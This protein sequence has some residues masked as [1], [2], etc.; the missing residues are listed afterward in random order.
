MPEIHIPDLINIG[1]V[2]LLVFAFV[3]GSMQLWVFGWVYKLEKARAD[4]WEEIARRGNEG[5]RDTLREVDH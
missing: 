2:S 5:W 1:S 3:T 4:K